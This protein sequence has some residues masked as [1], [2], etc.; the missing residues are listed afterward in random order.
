MKLSALFSAV[1]ALALVLMPD[2][3]QAQEPCT[4]KCFTEEQINKLREAVAELKNIHSSP[5]T[6]EIPKPIV[7]VRDFDGR[8]YVNGGSS[9]PLRMK[10]KIGKH[11]DRDVDVTLTPQIW[12]RPDPPQ[13]M[14][15]LRIRA[16][17]GVLV[18]ETFE[19]LS[20]TRDKYPIDAGLSWDFF[21]L[22]PVN[23]A[24]YTG[25]RSAGGGPGLD[26]TKNF[27]IYAGY[28]IVYDGFRSSAMA[29]AYFSFN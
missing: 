26:L 19:T 3:A 11:I 6:V 28:A 29:A 22:G 2:H 27:G 10:I 9:V 12:Y 20:G 13:P 17:A 23:L 4:G 5:V 1:L 8:V 7:I 16:Q 18:P 24:A 14:F 21:H 25:A 15:R